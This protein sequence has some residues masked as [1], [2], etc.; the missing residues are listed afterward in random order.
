MEMQSIWVLSQAFGD[1]G[2]LL[3]LLADKPTKENPCVSTPEVSRYST[4]AIP[5]VQL[6]EKG[7]LLRY[8]PSPFFCR[9]SF[10]KD[11]ACCLLPVFC[12]QQEP[13]LVGCKN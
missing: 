11:H 10:M 2:Y 8:F 6:S 9:A 4:A 1:P 3:S 7:N 12:W 13:L 5:Q